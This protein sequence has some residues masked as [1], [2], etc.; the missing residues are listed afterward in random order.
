VLGIDISQDRL[1][2][3]RASEVDLLESQLAELTIAVHSSDFQLTTDPAAIDGADAVV[4]CVPTPIDEHRLPELGPLRAACA[5]VVKHARRGQVII[6][7]STSF[8]GTTRQLLIDPL[9]NRG[10]TVGSDI[11]VAFSPERIDPGVDNH[12]LRETPRLIGADTERCVQR[13]ANVVGRLTDQVFSVSSPEVAELAKLYEN[14]FRAVNLALANEIA[15]ICRPLELDPIEVTAAAATKPYGFLACFPGPGVGGHCIPCDPHYL[16]WQLRQVP[17]PAPLID[18]AMTAIARRPQQVT[19]R[20]AEVLSDGGVALAGAK[21]MVVGVSYKPGVK[22]LRGSSAVEI[23]GQLIR[24]A[25]QVSYFDPL[26]PEMRLPTGQV[27]T[28]E[29]DPKGADWDLALIHTLHP[30]IDYAWATD[31]PRVLD[32]TYRFEAAKQRDVV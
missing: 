20:V 14:L 30:G 32:A 29:V 19:S 27:L 16:L 9:T 5:D 2:A 13:A 26:V 4:L 1:D 18:L 17:M 15:D 23:I 28:S 8:V 7:T 22:D 21:V 3:I 24:R 25:G 10:L 31:C 6:L 12:R 11:C